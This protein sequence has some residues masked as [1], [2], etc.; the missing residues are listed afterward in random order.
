M[1]MMTTSSKPYTLTLRDFRQGRYIPTSVTNF[2]A[3]ENSVKDALNVDFDKIVGSVQVRLGTT[4]LG[5]AVASG[6]TP[7]GNFTF[8]GHNGSPNLNLVVFKGTTNATL[9]Y[10]DTAWHASDQT[11]LS[12][13][14]KTRFATLGGRV[15]MTNTVDG[16]KSSVD[17]ATWT[18]DDCI[19][20]GLAKPAFI[21]RYGA[22]LLAAGDPT[23]PDRVFFSSIIDPTS[24]PFI[25]WAMTVSRAYTNDPIAGTNIALNMSD[26][27]GFIV[28]NT[29]TVSS[30]A[31]S[32]AATIVSLVANT[33]ITVNALDLDHTTTNPLVKQ[34]GDYIDINPDDGGIFSGFSETSTYILAL[35]NTGMYRMDTINKTA[36]PNNI[37]NIGAVSQE[38][39]TICQGITYFFSGIDVRRT[40]GGFP[41]EISRAGVQ[42][43]ID[44][45]PQA[46][47]GNVALGTDGLNVYASV[48]T[49]TLRTG[50]N[51]QKTITN[52]VL[53]FSTRDQNWTIYSYA[54]NFQFFSQL[55]NTNGQLLL[56]ADTSGN[57]QMI[58][59]GTTD[60]GTVINYNLELQDLEFGNRGHLKQ[61]SDQITV[62]MKNGSGSRIQC[63]E[64]GS[65]TPKDI[66]MKTIDDVN[67][68]EDIN[69]KGYYLNFIWYGESSGTAPIFEGIFLEN[70]A[71]LGNV[72]E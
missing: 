25:T 29:V 55:T 7:L 37:Y 34:A 53:K 54:Q 3:P 26:T 58:N 14:A 43:I 46:N 45:I 47:W 60:N 24:T 69:L 28:G 15:F 19:P 67:I 41:E 11:G 51:N 22:R 71:D 68:G 1:R 8:V 6:K 59:Y 10:F 20:S 49:V 61:I 65:V 35:K 42:D 57:V 48:G 9:Y 39:I 64:N 17:G 72:K 30:S 52:C 18:T 13:T 12:N 66:P 21:Y 27:S 31:G 32:E 44:A 16:M 38:A 5:A 23:Y 63:R 36:D 2:L 62:F 50:Q 70:I 33:S 40:N 56:G 4:L